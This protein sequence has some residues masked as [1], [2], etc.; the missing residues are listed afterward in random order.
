MKSNNN[1]KVSIA[2][3][4]YN[5]AE[6]IKAQLDSLCQQT[7]NNIEIVI[8]DDCSSDDT[9]SICN[10]Y[11]AKDNRIRTCQNTQNLGFNKNFEKAIS[12]CQGDYIAISDQDDIWC[13]DKI[14]VMLN[15]WKGGTVLMHHAAKSFHSEPLP[16]LDITNERD[17][18]I[19]TDIRYI[20]SGNFIQGCT[21][22]FSSSIKDTVL[23]FDANLLYDWWIGICAFSKGNV[24]YVHQN[25]IYHRKHLTSAH[26]SKERNRYDLQKELYDDFIRIQQANILA[27]K[28]AKILSE[29]IAVYKDLLDSK[30]SYKAVNWFF[31]NRKYVLWYKLNKKNPLVS[32]LVHCIKA[33]RGSKNIQ[34]TN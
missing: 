14:E 26:Y 4:T 16:S 32:Q 15:N 1:S 21:I 8:V 20:L 28:Q 9:V 34:P 12:L 27:P 29:V 31:K 5:G 13:L 10:E 17:A 2:L 22:L 7:Y 11:A 3:C 30:Y 33:G 23:P 6:Y 25:L 24:Q 19:C 18:S